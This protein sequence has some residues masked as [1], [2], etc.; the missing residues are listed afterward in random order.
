[1]IHSK[2][3]HC[4]SLLLHQSCLEATK[5]LCKSIVLA[6]TFIW[7]GNALAEGNDS[8]PGATDTAG[9]EHVAQASGS[10]NFRRENELQLSTM[11]VSDSALMDVE[12]YM[13]TSK[14]L[15][16]SIFR[17]SIGTVK[18]KLNSLK[19]AIPVTEI[20]LVVNAKDVRQLAAAN[21]DMFFV[22]SNRDKVGVE[23]LGFV[24][25]KNALAGL[26]YLTDEDTGK[27]ACEI[28]PIPQQDKKYWK[29]VDGSIA[30]EPNIANCSLS[31]KAYVQEITDIVQEPGKSRAKPRKK[32]KV[33]GEI[34]RY[35]SAGILH[36]STR[37]CLKGWEEELP[38]K[39]YLFLKNHE[40]RLAQK[41]LD[42]AG[43]M[44]SSGN[45]TNRYY[46]YSSFAETSDDDEEES[47]RGRKDVRDNGHV[48]DIF[49]A[50]LPSYWVA[51]Q[52]LSKQWVGLSSDYA[53]QAKAAKFKEQVKFAKADPQKMDKAW[54]IR[55]K[56]P[57]GFKADLAT[58]GIESVETQ[59]FLA[60]TSYDEDEDK[61]VDS[62][63]DNPDFHL[64]ISPKFMELSSDELSITFTPINVS[65]G[66]LEFA[67]SDEQTE[68]LRTCHEKHSQDRE[69]F[70]SCEKQV[71]ALEQSSKALSQ[72]FKEL[73]EAGLDTLQSDGSSTMTLTD[74]QLAALNM[75]R[76]TMLVEEANK[77]V[78]LTNALMR[79]INP[80]LPDSKL[81]HSGQSLA[82]NPNTPE[83]W[84][85]LDELPKGSEELEPYLAH[86]TESTSQD[87][88][89]M[90]DGD[91]EEEEEDARKT[92]L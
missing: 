40:D 39:R 5:A 14:E 54:Q 24:A 3:R 48:S 70:E 84:Q 30:M 44:A 11:D 37:V 67:D 59:Y 34:C 79:K 55:K 38:Y 31:F 26:V 92:E 12:G 62:Y 32:M 8:E 43:S 20:E 1:M 72:S 23:L 27:T 73:I 77:A 36:K 83:L 87:N 71:S 4:S 85:W 56:T 33:G 46:D 47:S 64:E 81:Y 52:Q 78:F 25:M 60:F 15:G 22:D 91:V 18:D 57:K 41:I 19:P 69:S 29:D 9:S 82:A 88:A 7:V 51:T 90:D 68:A 21:P 53:N 80:N 42:D 89:D 6:S 63:A 16:K 28:L 86:I 35:P 2:T 66:A 45:I 13:I 75:A 50:L 10:K 61:E 49:G 58:L 65:K 17:R 76:M 74:K